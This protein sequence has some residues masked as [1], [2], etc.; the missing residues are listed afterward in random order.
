MKT[1]TGAEGRTALYALAAATGEAVLA[2]GVSREEAQ[3][4]ARAGS[5]RTGMAHPPSVVLLKDA[6]AF[7]ES[8]GSLRWKAIPAQILIDAA[9]IGR[10]LAER[11]GERLSAV[12]P[13][14]AAVSGTEEKAGAPPDGSGEGGKS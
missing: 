6:T 8:A 9:G 5:E 4:L 13:V 11:I 2:F 14:V 1:L 3:A 7:I 12:A 10:G